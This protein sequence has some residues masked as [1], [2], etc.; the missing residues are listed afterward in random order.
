MKVEGKKGE[1]LKKWCH[2]YQR[3]PF[4]KARKNYKTHEMIL[5]EGDEREYRM[6][7]DDTSGKIYFDRYN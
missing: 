1:G 4:E 5:R 2:L 3:S 6:G 7:L